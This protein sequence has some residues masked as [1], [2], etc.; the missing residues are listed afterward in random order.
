MALFAEH[1]TDGVHYVGFAAS[2]R[3]DDARGPSAAERYHRAFAERFES[4][5]FHFSEF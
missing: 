5:D 2:V 4:G 3:A 1:P